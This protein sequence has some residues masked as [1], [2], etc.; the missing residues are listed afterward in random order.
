MSRILVTLVYERKIGSMLRKAV[1]SCMADRANDDG[2]GI[3]LSKGR[4]ADE[5]EASRRSVITAIQGLVDDGLLIDHGLRKAGSTHEYSIH[6]ETLADMPRHERTQGGCENLHTPDPVKDVH[7]GV[8]E[9]HRGCEA[10]SHKPSYNRPE[11][12]PNGVNARETRKP[13]KAKKVTKRGSRIAETWAPTP[14]DYA[15]ASKKGLNPQEINHEADQFRDYHIAKGTISKD[16][17][18]SWRTWCRNAVKW[19]SERK[20]ATRADRHAERAAVFAEVAHEFDHGAVPGRS[21]EELHQ[22]HAQASHSD[23]GSQA[24]LI[25]ADGVELVWDGGTSDRAA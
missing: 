7:G 23:A 1:L 2:S 20:P 18:A 12:T 17:A 24:T 4:I 15:H 10:A 16:W 8:K 11:P 22:T 5:I 3:W 25:D 14:V 9:V 19:K 21:G 13:P 6:V